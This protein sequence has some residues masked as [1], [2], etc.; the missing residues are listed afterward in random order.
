MSKT[1]FW[2]DTGDKLNNAKENLQH[3]LS[4]DY[5]QSAI[6]IRILDTFCVFS[7]DGIKLKN[8]LFLIKDNIWGARINI[9]D[10]SYV[11]FLLSEKKNILYCATKIFEK[12]D[13]NKWFFLLC[14]DETGE[15]FQVN[16]IFTEPNDKLKLVKDLSLTR[17]FYEVSCSDMYRLGLG[18][19]TIRSYISFFSSFSPP[20]EI[21]DIFLNFIEK[22]KIE[23][24]N[25]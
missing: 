2:K 17:D 12:E 7:N 9:D 1:T 8:D 4:R 16:K 18:F 20:Q 5:L 13:K 25:E 15:D 11:A 24:D 3:S 10:S 14:G 23:E 21:L 22:V 19:E 6:T